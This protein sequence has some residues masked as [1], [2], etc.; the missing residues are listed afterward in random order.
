MTT[1]IIL[2]LLLL[3]IV[4]CKNAIQKT[5]AGPAS[6]LFDSR[7]YSV[8]KLTTTGSSLR[9]KLLHQIYLSH[10]NA[11]LDEKAKITDS[12]SFEIKE[13]VNFNQNFSKLIISYS[14]REELFYIPETFSKESLNSMLNLKLESGKSWVWKSDL[15]TGKTAYLVEVSIEEILENEKKFSVTETN[16]VKSIY[17]FQEIEIEMEILVAVPSFPLDLVHISENCIA[18][19]PTP[20]GGYD[21]KIKFVENNFA[22]T[23]VKNS[24]D[25]PIFFNFI[26]GKY[27]YAIVGNHENK[28]AETISLTLPSELPSHFFITYSDSYNN[29]YSVSYDLNKHLSYNFIFKIFGSNQTVE[30]FG[31]L[32]TQIP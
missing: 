13:D 15:K 8:N 11:I 27:K 16:T 21:P 1:K 32:P 26:D 19:K 10:S 28:I 24:N 31:I 17:P 9:R 18:Y 23:L 12:D 29:I 7:A 22:G 4:A 30:S 14:D 5:E 6:M 20:Q 3:Q 25:F 2:F